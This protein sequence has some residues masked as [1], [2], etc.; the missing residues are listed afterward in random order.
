VIHLSPTATTVEVIDHEHWNTEVRTKA[1]GMVEI[2]CV[3]KAPRV[4]RRI[5]DTLFIQ[6]IVAN[7]DLLMQK[8]LRIQGDIQADIQN[9]PSLIHAGRVVVQTEIQERLQLISLSE[10]IFTADVQSAPPGVSIK[11]LLNGTEFDVTYTATQL[12]EQEVPVK[13]NIRYAT[14]EESVATITLQ[15]YGEDGK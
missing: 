4:P 15:Y 11:P 8:A 2:H 5:D 13:F 3:A 10:S 12:G 14:G 7:G 6:P 1:D 9:R